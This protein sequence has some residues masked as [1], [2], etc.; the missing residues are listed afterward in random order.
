MA[1]TLMTTTGTLEDV[2]AAL[3]IA[4]GSAPAPTEE[5]GPTSASVESLPVKD[6]TPVES[7]TPV[8]ATPES[9]TT[10]VAEETVPDSEFD[11]D[12][13]PTTERAARSSRTKLQTIKKL[14]I[15]AR[16]AEL[17]AA[18]AEGELKARQELTSPVVPKAPTPVTPDD[19]QAP[20]EAAYDTYEAFIK[21]TAAHEA[22]LAYRAEQARHDAQQAVQRQRETETQQ[23]QAIADAI[24]AFEVDHP[25]YREVVNN[26]D[27]TL[28]PAVAHALRKRPQ[29]APALAYALGKDPDRYKRIAAM[30]PD[31]T[32]EAIGELRMELR[33]A[34]IPKAEAKPAIPIKQPTAPPPPTPVRGGSVASAVS[35]EE[36]AKTIT[37]GDPKTS[38]W[39]RRRNEQL[40]R[41]GQR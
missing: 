12:G 9:A 26:P 37:P 21:A 6:L 24:Q 39:L 5:P 2:N 34:Q 35:L 1:V 33:Q 30:S 16:E 25:D 27:L 38:E 8:E 28:T 18:R 31:D 14:R 41:Q 22:R 32:F 19:D 11:E 15:R 40:Q 3:G 36:F 23:Q 17:R 20:Q 29:D 7:A 13:E 4:A 10:P